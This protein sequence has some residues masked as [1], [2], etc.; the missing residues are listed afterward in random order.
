[1][2]ETRGDID[3]GELATPPRTMSKDL[4]EFIEQTR[5]DAFA[6]HDCVESLMEMLQGCPPDHQ[7]SAGPLAALLVLVQAYLDNVVDGM[8]AEE[9]AA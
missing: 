8:R 1:M 9:A 6:A 7:L 3:A 4:R 2:I 5:A